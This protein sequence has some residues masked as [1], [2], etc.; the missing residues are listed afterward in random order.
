[1]VGL[2]SDIAAGAP[3][4]Q[5]PRLSR[6][7][8]DWA[9]RVG[10]PRRLALALAA[11]AVISG[12]LTYTALSGSAPFAPDAR[13]VLILLNI[14]LVLLLLLGAV[15]ALRLVRLW[16]ERRR[17][18]AGSRLHTRMVALFSLV[19]V[20]P[21]IVVAI[22]SALFL[23]FGMHAWFSDKVSTA[24]D[25]SVVVAEAYLAEHRAG[26]RA[27]ALAMAAD[28]NREAP[29]VSQ[30]PYRMNQLVD[31]LADLR[32]LTEAIVVRRNGLILARNSLSF[33]LEFER[34]PERAMLAAE[35]GDV[36]ILT[37]E[38]EDRVRALVRLDGY[39]DALLLV[40]RFIESEVLGHMQ[41]VQSVVGEYQR[42]EN[43]RSGIQI[44]FVLIFVVVALLVLFA[45]VWVG[46]HFANQLA[47][48]IG[49]LIAAAERV[50]AGD[51]A[52]RVSESKPADELSSLTRSFNRMTGQLQSQ[53]EA[54]LE[55]NQQLDDRRRFTEAVLAGVSAGV[56]GLDAR[57]HITLPNPSALALLDVEASALIG[58]PLEAAIPEMADL[59]AAARARPQR[60][61]ERQVELLRNERR[62]ALLVRIVS[63]RAGQ[64][65][66]GFVVTF[67]DITALV[68]AQRAAAW[69]DVARRIAHEIKNP[70]TP[71]QLAAERLKRKYLGEI[72]S[73]PDIF[74]A[75]TDTIV[76]QVGDIRQM[77]DEFSS[78]AR[79]PAPVLK[80]VELG[81]L[82]EDAVVLQRVANPDI[83]YTIEEPGHPVPVSCDPR[84]ISQCLTNLQNNAREAIAA[85][86]GGGGE[87]LAPGRVVVRLR[88]D[89][90]RWLIDVEDNGPGLPS[91]DRDRL[92]EPY[93]TTRARGTGL[94]LA[95]VRKIM[96]D[97][98]GELILGT[99][100]DGGACV[101]LAFAASGESAPDGG[102]A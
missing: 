69:A 11:G 81:A 91:E 24:L 19:A 17:G 35:A 60:V 83:E 80:S 97:H 23:D 90:G 12:A 84:Q 100:A 87:A 34:I 43:E 58:H 10:L 29:R 70:L 33:A 49:G 18:S 46:L 88:R 95:I 64:E 89:D 101:S 5:K 93:V 94:G 66:E 22:F 3:A 7:L 2:D 15:V 99:G 67:D 72:D 25:R 82:I 40:G 98:G 52:T 75:C 42:L 76:R 36:V 47:H 20:T 39:V 71:I 68:S 50:R 102:A 30:N 56:I 96:E 79:M 8:L 63:E 44:T 9:N 4:P 32:S 38:N 62:R 92:T 31:R 6:R 48:P 73:E 74:S 78:F 28:L 21:T 41:Q 57:G 59:L 37:D 16:L 53:Q 26:I 13:N 61:V 1:M 27:D 45:A 14:D 86:E 77:V 65:I 54:L 55:A 85:R 51:L